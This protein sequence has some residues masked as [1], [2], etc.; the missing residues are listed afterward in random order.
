MVAHPNSGDAGDEVQRGGSGE[1]GVGWWTSF[2]AV[3]RKKLTGRMRSVRCGRPEGNDGGG[4]R[5]G[6]VVG[7]S[8]GGRSYTAARCSGCGR[9]SQRGAGVSCPRWLSDGEQGGAG[10]VKVAE[11]EKV[12]PRG[13]GRPL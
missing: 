10:A 9:G 2:G 6:V 12:T 8:R 11:E 1:Q 4:Q 7:S 13:G 5:P 3:G